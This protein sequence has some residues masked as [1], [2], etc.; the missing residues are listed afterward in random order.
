M[1]HF[2]HILHFY[3]WLEWD[4]DLLPYL[5]SEWG[6]ESYVVIRSF[7]QLSGLLSNLCSCVRCLWIYEC[8]YCSSSPLCCGRSFDSTC[9]FFFLPLELYS[10]SRTYFL[11]MLHFLYRKLFVVFFYALSLTL[12]SKWWLS[13]KRGLRAFVWLQKGPSCQCWP[14]R[15]GREGELIDIFP[16]PKSIL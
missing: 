11:F 13:V 7:L 4:M 8:G 14:I 2:S 5:F 15:W 12:I 3:V 1:G 16:P 6:T 10:L 9:L